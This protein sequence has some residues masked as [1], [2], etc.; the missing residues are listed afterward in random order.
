[1]PPVPNT[2]GSGEWQAYARHCKA[3]REGPGSRRWYTAP[4][5]SVTQN[6]HTPE[7]ESSDR[8]LS[9]KQGD[10]IGHETVK[11]SRN[12]ISG[13]SNSLVALDMLT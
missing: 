1:M 12:S 3:E 9:V 8:L 4:S 7:R 11:Q 5:I 10:R 6:P 13:L 2:T